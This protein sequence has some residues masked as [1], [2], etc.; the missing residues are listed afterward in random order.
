MLD[1]FVANTGRPLSR[2]HL[3]MAALGRPHY[4]TDR[5]IDNLVA[6]LRRKLRDSARLASMIKTA[7]PVGYVF[8]GFSTTEMDA[9]PAATAGGL[10]LP[11][12][13]YYVKTD[14]KSEETR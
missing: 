10:G 2:D 14:A 5:G 3:S 11:D 12:R 7:R 1:A 8:T 9:A 4:A 6:K 13:D